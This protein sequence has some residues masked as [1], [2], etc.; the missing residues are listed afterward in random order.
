VAKDKRL[1]HNHRSDVAMSIEV[2]IASAYT[3][4]CD[5]DQYLVGIWGGNIDLSYLYNAWFN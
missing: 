3:H 4:G 5:L 2:H 1:V